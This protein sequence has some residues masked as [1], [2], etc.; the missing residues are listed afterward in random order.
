MPN[1]R[2]LASARAADEH[3]HSLREQFD[4]NDLNG[5]GRLTLGEF[6]RFMRSTDAQIKADEC[7]QGF[8]EIDLDRDG[9]IDFAEF[10]AW[11]VKPT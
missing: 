4:F 3:R 6:I 8:D 1:H 9:L 11:W 7:E 5:D 10:V 2:T